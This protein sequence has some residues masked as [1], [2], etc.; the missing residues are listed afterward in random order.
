M[1][2]KEIINF[3]RSVNERESKKVSQ[4]GAIYDDLDVEINAFQ[5]KS[6]LQC[7]KGCG[8][9][10]TNPE[11]ETSVL[12]MLPAAFY[13]LK[14][15]LS[16]KYEEKL[17]ENKRQCVFYEP[18]PLIEGN[19]RCGI[20]AFRPLICRL[21]GFSANIRKANNPEL[22]TCE[23]IKKDQKDLFE[24]SEEEIK[25]GLA[26]PLMQKY[27]MQVTFLDSAGQKNFPINEAIFQAI[28]KIGLVL[29]YQK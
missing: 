19:G 26:V 21:F 8:Q 3:I 10:C 22:I 15:N 24:K 28:Q 7:I 4:L 20:Y 5:K 18:D 27:M 11:I 16:K 25:K 29:R 17:K 12:E 6:G 13:L 23:R 1:D 9:C 14:N 2:F